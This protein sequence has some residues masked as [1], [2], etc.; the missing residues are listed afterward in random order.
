M[1][2]DGHIS[3]ILPAGWARLATLAAFVAAT[4]TGLTDAGAQNTSRDSIQQAPDSS[5]LKSQETQPTFR[6]RAERNLVLVRAIVRDSKGRVARALRKEDFRLFDNGKPQTITHFA[7]EDASQKPKTPDKAGPPAAADAELQPE[8]ELAPS[9]P[10]RYLAL[11][12]DDAHARFE[13]LAR[14]RDAGGRYLASAP[15][16]GDRIGIFTSS[17]QTT[18]DFTD[19]REKL[20]ATLIRLQP[21]S[22]LSENGN[23]CPEVLPYQAYLIIHR[24]DPLALEVATEEAIR[25]YFQNLQISPDAARQQAQQVAEGEATRVLNFFETRSEYALRGLDQLIRRMTALP[26]QRNI[27]LVSPGFLTV[28]QDQRRDAIA[29]RAL[30]ANVIISSLDARGLYVP[31]PF[32]DVSQRPIV[33][34]A[35]RAELTGFKMRLQIESQERGADVLRYLAQDTGGDFFHNSNDLDEGFRRVGALREVSYVL[36]FSPSSLKPD[37]RFHSLKVTLASSRGMTIQA[38]RGYFAPRKPEDASTLANEEIE[39]TLFSR[40]EVN[41]VPIEVHTQFFRLNESETRISVLTHL[42]LRLLRFRKEEGRNLN[43]LTVVTA[44]FDR[45]GKCLTAK[46]KRLEFRL[47]DGSLERLSQSGLNMKTSF[48]VRPGT[49]LVREVVRDSEGGQLSGL[50]RTVEIPY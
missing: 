33:N 28:T 5:E 1:G 11:F 20:R 6:V 38:R 22:I 9:T 44:L 45:D 30:R 4:L 34:L 3:R 2:P 14:S 39:Q 16:P 26:G 13:D 27:V 15:L 10:H 21:R 25:C 47:R 8:T 50:N 48:D 12:F 17:G 41:E 23:S 24:R 42:D 46:E 37:G 31:S 18:L 7:L 49:Y 32:D 43:N 40:D 35:D 36:G 29:D 19:D